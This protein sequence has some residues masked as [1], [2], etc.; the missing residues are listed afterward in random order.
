MALLF[1]VNSVAPREY[2]LCRQHLQQ[3][4]RVGHRVAE[5]RARLYTDTY[6]VEGVACP[7]RTVTFRVRAG[8]SSV[9][10]LRGNDALNCVR[11]RVDV[12]SPL[13]VD[14]NL[15]ERQVQA[16]KEEADGY[17]GRRTGLSSLDGR[18]EACNDL[19][20]RH[21]RHGNSEDHENVEDVVL[22]GWH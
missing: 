22:E 20:N 19:T 6:A 9:F 7:S 8:T 12:I 3:Q 21:E 16:A 2:H 13:P 14:W 17:E 5:T 4:Q 1:I 11:D 10:E 15:R 18:A